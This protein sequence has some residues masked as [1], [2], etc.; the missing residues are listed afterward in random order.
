MSNESRVMALLEEGNP[1]PE[2]G[3]N[4][5]KVLD[6]AT[7]LATLEQRISEMT[8]LETN[9]SQRDTQEKRNR[10]WLAAAVFALVLG[11]GVIVFNQMNPV[12]IAAPPGIPLEGAEDH[13]GAA[14]AFSAVEAA[15]A[16]FSAG[17]PAW[18]EIRGR[19]SDYGSTPEEVEANKEAERGFWMTVM[20]ASARYDVSSCV[21]QGSGEWNIADPGIPTPTGHSF[22]CEV[23]ETNPLLD[24]AGASL[25]FTT[26]WVVDDSGVVAAAGG[27]ETGDGNVFLSRFTG[28]LASTHP[29]ATTAL[30]ALRDA[31]YFGLGDPETRSEILD[32]AEEFVAQTDVYP[33]ESTDA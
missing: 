8:K 32:Y 24:I 27:P 7:Y 26:H 30:S 23:T 16:L 19:G 25:S 22:V 13:P 31:E 21:A 18:G 1:A 15:Y 9:E 33:L 20:A 2:L 5:W 14:E 17:D 4:A 29:E 12:P 6:A 10:P 3:E 11:V 28:W